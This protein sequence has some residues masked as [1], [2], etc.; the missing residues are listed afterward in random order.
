MDKPYGI[1][2]VFSAQGQL[3]SQSDIYF[4]QSVANLV[5]MILHQGRCRQ[6][7][8]TVPVIQTNS[9]I[10]SRILE[11]DRREIKNRL[12]ESQE[13]ERLRLA[14]DPRYP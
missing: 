3:F 8:G 6:E 11:W 10:Q 9:A 13:R 2:Q 4:L 14:Q 7:Q 5:G 1:L 12:V